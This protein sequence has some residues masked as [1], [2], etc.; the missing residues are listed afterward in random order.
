[1]NKMAVLKAVLAFLTIPAIWVCVK[2]IVC[3]ITHTAFTPMVFSP[4]IVESIVL[5]S[6]F[7]A[8]YV[9]KQNTTGLSMNQ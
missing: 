2:F 4:L 7:N 9:Y 6:L 3:M 5:A 8:F 1:M